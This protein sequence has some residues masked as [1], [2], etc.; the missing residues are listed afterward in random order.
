MLSISSAS[1]SKRRLLFAVAT[2][3]VLTIVEEHGTQPKPF[4][5]QIEKRRSAACIL[6]EE[7]MR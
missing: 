7:G 1:E 2:Y 3:R 5:S 4:Y 6:I